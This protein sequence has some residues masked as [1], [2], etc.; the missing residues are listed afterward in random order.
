MFQRPGDIVA[1]VRAGAVDFGIAG[2]DVVAER[3]G[4]AAV[5]IVHEALRYGGCALTVAVPAE[6]PVQTLA[7]LHAYAE[8]QPNP[9]R[10][11]THYPNLAGRFLMAQ[12]LRSFALVDA[13]GTL[14]VAPALGYADFI[15]DLVSSG[16]TLHDNHLRP[17]ADGVILQSQAVLIANRAALQTRPAVLALAYQLLEY[18]EAHLRAEDNYLVVANMRGADPAAIARAV[19]AQPDLSGLQGPTVAPV[20]PR[21]GEP[22]Q[23]VSLIVAKDRL[24]PSVKALRAVGGSGVVVTPVTYIFEEEPERARRLKASLTEAG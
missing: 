11:A 5:L 8:A 17:L 2:L 18:I 13:E 24:I 6:W 4:D 14:E 3:G 12:G 23:S 22:G 1:S 21:A 20:Y 7:D 16:Q 9:L 15:A 10:V 19:L